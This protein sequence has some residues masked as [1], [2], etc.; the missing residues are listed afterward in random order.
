MGTL[1]LVDEDRRVAVDLP[2]SALIGRAWCCTP[3]VRAAFCPL[4]WLELRWTAS[5]WAW[6]ALAAQERTRGFG[7]FLGAEW[8]SLG[9]QAGRGARVRLDDAVW[10]E[11]VDSAPPRP[12]A[13]DVE[14]GESLSGAALAELV[15]VRRDGVFPIEAEGAPEE[16]FGEGSVVRAGGRILRVHPGEPVPATVRTRLDLAAD[17]LVIDLNLHERIA[18]L[19]RGARHEDAAVQVRGECVRVLAVFLNARIHGEHDGWLS[20]AN[21]WADWNALG[22]AKDSPIERLAFERAKLR[23]QLASAGAGSVHALFERRRE[24]SLTL[25]RVRAFERG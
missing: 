24:G 4:Y 20:A 6:R 18:T 2:A 23:D 25:T 21:A 16:A 13:I 17:G 3:R 15:E 8:R 9:A 1:L 7:T 22:G 11:L 14:T 10:I 5:Q 19:S 12:C